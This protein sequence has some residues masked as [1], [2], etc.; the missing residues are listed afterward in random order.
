MV[1]LKAVGR[2]LSQPHTVRVSTLTFHTTKAPM[3]VAPPLTMVWSTIS[4]LLAQQALFRSEWSFVSLSCRVMPP[5]ANAESTEMLDAL[6]SRVVLADIQYGGTLAD[7]VDRIDE[8]IASVSLPTPSSLGGTSASDRNKGSLSG[9]RE[10][11][12]AVAYWP[13]RAAEPSRSID[14]IQPCESRRWPSCDASFAAGIFVGRASQQCRCR[15]VITS[16]YES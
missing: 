9:G 10:F 7:S 12:P 6:R 11:G 2:W 15:F 16:G 14:A 1:D 4:T 5:A 13:P 8:L 3:L